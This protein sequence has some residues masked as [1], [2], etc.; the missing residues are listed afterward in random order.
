MVESQERNQMCLKKNIKQRIAFAREHLNKDQKFWNT[1]LWSDECKF[2]VF[3]ND[4]RAYVRRPPGKE[5]D[6]KYTKKTVKHGGSSVMVWGCF[7]SCGVG[8][9]VEINGNMT[10]E[11]YK[12]ILKENLKNDFIDNLPLLWT[13][14]QDNDPKH[15]SKVVKTWMAKNKIRVMKWPAQ[16]PDFN[17]IENL[18]AI[19]KRS[20]AAIKPKN[21]TDL[22]RLIKDEW[23]KVTPQQCSTL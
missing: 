16:S 11:I 5:L 13:F 1:V 8:P 17:P 12:D 2:N 7:A 6:P 10:G 15:C 19:S 23:R 4:G 14:Q 18:L 9:I 22:S 20:V 3:G 21:K